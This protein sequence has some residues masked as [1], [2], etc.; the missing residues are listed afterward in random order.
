MSPHKTVRTHE[1]GDT[2]VVSVGGYLNSL[3]GEEVEKVVRAE[4]EGGGR[5]ILLNFG[6]TRLVN[7][8]GISF[9]IGIVEKVMEREG[10][11]AFCEVSRINRDLFQVTGLAKYVRSF[12]TE[13][14]ALD[15]LS[16]NA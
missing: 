14:E 10:R 12:E 15:Y 16:G 4:L 9:V 5:R 6:G 1:M 3:L 7:S 13:K 11:M 2:L 8:I